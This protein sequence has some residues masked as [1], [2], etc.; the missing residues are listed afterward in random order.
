M[1]GIYKITSPTKKIYIGQSKHIEKRL[2]F[3]KKLKCEN[4]QLIY[5]SLKKHGINKHKFEILQECDI[6]KLD[7]LEIYY[8]EL[9]QTFK[10]NYGLN[11]TKGGGNS[12]SIFKSKLMREYFINKNLPI[13]SIIDSVL[14]TPGSTTN[15][16]EKIPFYI[17]F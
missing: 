8:I 13:T 4:Q 15:I 7:E 2:K 6:E 1:I 17:E 5:N 14:P 16:F 12:Y 10:N 3:Y 11:L 9:F